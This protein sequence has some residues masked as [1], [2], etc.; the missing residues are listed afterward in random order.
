MKSVFKTFLTLLL[1]LLLMACGD[2]QP[3]VDTVQLRLQEMVTAKYAAYKTAN[4]L[5]ENAG[6]L[7]YLQSPSGARLAT[8]GFTTSVNENFHYRVASVTKTFTASAI[9]LLDQQGKLK[10]DD[11]VTAT[12]PGKNSPYLPDSSTYAIPYKNLITI[13][14]LLSH[15]AGVFDI[16]N[17]QVPTSS[18]AI[19]AGKYYPQYIISDLNEPDHQFTFDELVGVVALNQLSYWAPDADYHYS[20]TGYTL[21]AMI[22]ERVSGKSYDQFITE[23]FIIPMGLN[24]TSAPRS[25]SDRTIPSPYL[26]GY[27]NLGA[28]FLETTEDNMSGNVAE[29]NIIGTPADMAR[30]IKS[31]LTGRGPLTKEQIT[32]MTTVSAGS[33]TKY[34]LGIASYTDIGMGH[35][36]AHQGFM[37]LV[38]YNPQD[39][40][41]MVV[42]LPF[43]DFNKVSEQGSFLLEIGKE[44]RKIAGY[45]EAWPKP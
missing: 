6:A 15:R 44:A 4:N 22:I 28:G 45:T 39:D 7:V 21:L 34:A 17:D 25:S 27:S 13:R 38:V 2:D 1:P 18:N 31:L 9:M 16:T 40:L 20:N 30:W 43:V 41:T 33:T 32:R 35:T 11:F 24:A 26:R 10:I 37:N 3:S 36:G 42:V 23:N 12:I 14:Q 29:G 8:A 5:P 19:Y